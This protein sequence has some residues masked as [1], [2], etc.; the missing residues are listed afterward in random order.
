MKLS[1]SLNINV[2]VEDTSTISDGK[3]IPSPKQH[4][5]MNQRF[6]TTETCYNNIK[7]VI[8]FD[9]VNKL[10]SNYQKHVPPK[11]KIHPHSQNLLD[12]HREKQ[13]IESKH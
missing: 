7:H 5:K 11:N 8:K 4:G 13:M 12:P 10:S 6:L 1:Q 3:V 2:E 9:V